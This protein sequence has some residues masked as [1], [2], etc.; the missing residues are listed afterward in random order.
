MGN[1]LNFGRRAYGRGLPLVLYDVE[2]AS[3]TVATGRGRWLEIQSAGTVSA[4]LREL[5]DAIDARIGSG[6]QGK[7]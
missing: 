4:A 5:A 1:I 3:Y 2:T 7:P 6:A